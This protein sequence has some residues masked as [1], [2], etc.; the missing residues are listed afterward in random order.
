MTIILNT[1]ERVKR[2]GNIAI[3]FDSDIDVIRNK[4]IVDGKSVLGIF[5]LDLR[6]PVDV[7]IHSSDEK[8]IRRFNEAMEEF[9]I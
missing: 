3:K 9:K 8:E 6:K 5:T 7:E 1:L 2:F 4:Y